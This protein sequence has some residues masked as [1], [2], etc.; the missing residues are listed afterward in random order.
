MTNWSIIQ[1]TSMS[2]YNGNNYKLQ[3]CWQH[4][5]PAVSGCCFLF[6]FLLSYLVI[7]RGCYFLLSATTALFQFHLLQCSQSCAGESSLWAKKK[8]IW[9]AHLLIRTLWSFPDAELV[10]V[11][12]KTLHGITSV[13][14]PD[15]HFYSRWS[16]SAELISCLLNPA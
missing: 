6:F 4:S 11:H 15:A 5:T 9:Q 14:R 7:K 13:V 12:Y 1:I 3:P 2:T 16:E 8:K 10:V